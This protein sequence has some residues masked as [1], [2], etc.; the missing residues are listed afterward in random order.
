MQ[1][2]FVESFNGRLRDECL[3]EHLFTNLNEA[4]RIIE[5]WRIDYNTNRPHTS[6]NGLTPTEFATRPN[7]GQ[8]RTDSPYK[9]GQT[10]EQVTVI[11]D[12][13]FQPIAGVLARSAQHTKCFDFDWRLT[14]L[15]TISLGAPLACT[16]SRSQN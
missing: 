5:E 13:D 3:N 10:G 1:N 7:R 12:R 15:Y 9:R 6:L 14:R 8:P 11:S 16:G 2:G 4:R